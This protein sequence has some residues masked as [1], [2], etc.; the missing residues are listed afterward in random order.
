MG[1]TRT[2]RQLRAPS[3][4]LPITEFAGHGREPLDHMGCP[5]FGGSTYCVLWDN[6]ISIEATDP[7]I[8][9]EI[10]SD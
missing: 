8:A 7:A 1:Q 10:A 3:A 5:F 2:Q 6:G 9:N 4:F